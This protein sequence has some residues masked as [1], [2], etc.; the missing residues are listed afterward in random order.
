MRADGTDGSWRDF[1]PLSAVCAV[2][3][4]LA[5]SA[6][7]MMRGYY[8][9]LDQQSFRRDA[10]YYATS[11]KDDVARHVTSL[12][13]IRAFVSASRG[14][15]RWEFSAYA[16]QIMPQNLGFRAILWVPSVARKDRPASCQVS[17]GSRGS[18]RS[19]TFSRSRA[20]RSRS[21]TS[22]QR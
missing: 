22:R 21:R 5:V 14:V 18:S 6:F 10:T 20:T 17:P 9:T 8:Q 2:G 12:A 3:F 7:V 1:L 11:F 4:A 16:Q 15:S 19:T 13:A